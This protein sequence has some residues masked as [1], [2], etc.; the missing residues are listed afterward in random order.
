MAA[1]MDEM[2][3]WALNGYTLNEA[4]KAQIEELKMEAKK[5]Y[6]KQ[7]GA[8]LYKKDT[9]LFH[10]IY[11]ALLEYTNKKYKI[12][13]K[14][15]IYKQHGINTYEINDIITKFW[16]ERESIVK[17]FCQINPFTFTKEELSLASDFQKGICSMFILAKFQKEYTASLT[18][19]KIYMVKGI[20]DN[21]DNMFSLEEIPKVVIT[22]IIPFNNVLVFDGIFQAMNISL[23][24]NFAKMIKEKYSKLTKYYYLWE[25]HYGKRNRRI[26]FIYL[27]GMKG[28]FLLEG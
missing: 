12:N 23:G 7:W 14:V 22:S 13:P 8:C 24:N 18:E 17:G 2:P 26:H 10:K 27:V 21:L 5:E 19:D 9:K 16:T 11:F 4:R 1:T 20:N 3:S 6:E 25:N 15:Q 28:Y